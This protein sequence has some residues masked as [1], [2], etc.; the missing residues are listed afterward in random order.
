M[1]DAGDV[2]VVTMSATYGAGGSRGGTSLAERLGLPFADRLILASDTAAPGA[3]TERVTEDERRQYSRTRFLARLALV[4]GGLGVPVP[5]AEA[6]GGGVQAQVEA[7]IHQE[8]AHDGAVILGRAAAV[9]LA[10]HPRAFHVRLDG[11]NARRVQRGMTI[12][13]IDEATARARLDET[14][15]ARS[16][17]VERVYGRPRRPRPLPPVARLHGDRHRGLRRHRR[18]GG[19]GVLGRPTLDPRSA[20][21]GFPASRG[22]RR[23]GIAALRVGTSGSHLGPADRG[24][25]AERRDPAVVRGSQ[26]GKPGEDQ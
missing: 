16:R 12:E 21:A 23:F 8:M 4:T 7:S 15:R 10:G 1:T 22:P 2:R 9:V 20:A 3:G 17:Y 24:C 5:T 13:R 18:G 19:Q 25:C 14:D 6:V 11:P 26:T